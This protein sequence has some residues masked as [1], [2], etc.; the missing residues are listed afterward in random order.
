MSD[1]AQRKHCDIVIPAL[2][3]AEIAPVNLC[4]QRETFLRNTRFEAGR[5]NCSTQRDQVGCLTVVGKIGHMA[6]IAV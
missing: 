1:L 5:T 3:P 6:I 4:K 2:N